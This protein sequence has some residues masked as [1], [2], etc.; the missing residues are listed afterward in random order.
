MPDAVLVFEERQNGEQTRA[1]E[2]R[3]AEILR[4]ERERELQARV[5]KIAR[6]FRVQGFPGLEVGQHREQP[7]AEQARPP[8]KRHLQTRREFLQLQA[9]VR[10]ELSELRA[11][12]RRQ[13]R[14]LRH[15]PLNVGRGVQLAT[16]P[17]GQPVLRVEPGHRNFLEQIA[18]HRLKNLLKD[19]GI[20]KERRAQIKAVAIALDGRSATAHSRLLFQNRDFH[21]G[22][23]QQH[24]RGQTA[25][26]R[27]HYDDPSGHASGLDE[28][29]NHR[30]FRVVYHFEV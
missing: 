5:G 12:R 17:E 19:L 1:L 22:L 18:P 24:G 7:Q 4:L 20:E 9:I 13:F 30:K 28:I 21:A 16:S 14:N 27:S 2:R 6:E 25:R 23:G 8:G 29:R 10:H 15:H 3:H 26:S 11:V